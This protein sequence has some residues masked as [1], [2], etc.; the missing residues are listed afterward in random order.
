ME[1]EG[2]EKALVLRG[3]LVYMAGAR[4]V[5]GIRCEEFTLCEQLRD[6]PV[7]QVSAGYVCFHRYRR[8]VV[9]VALCVCVCVCVCARGVYTRVRASR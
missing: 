9:V 4:S 1:G 3:G 5:L 7:R 6:T 2:E 8:E